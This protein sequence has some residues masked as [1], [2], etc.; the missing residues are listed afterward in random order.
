MNRETEV[1]RSRFEEFKDVPFPTDSEEESLSEIF[2]LLISYDSYI[3]GYITRIIGGE[4]IEPQK[5]ALDAEIDRLR[6]L[7]DGLE[8]HPDALAYKMYFEKL[9]KIVLLAN[10]QNNR[11]RR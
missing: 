2:L 9:T 5:L 7:R 4:F 10:E 1:R 8:L 6:S 11:R 3:A